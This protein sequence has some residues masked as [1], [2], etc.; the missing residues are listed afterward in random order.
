MPKPLWLIV[1]V[2]LLPLG[3][4]AYL[5]AGRGVDEEPPPPPSP[6]PRV[7]APDDDPDFLRS[8]KRRPP[9]DPRRDEQA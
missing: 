3:G 4:V 9:R 7:K 8:L 2:L 6:G 1:I 5:V